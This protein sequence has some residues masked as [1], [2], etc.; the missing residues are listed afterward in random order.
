MIVV[1]MILSFILIFWVT[2]LTSQVSD[3]KKTAQ[4]NLEVYDK[5]ISEIDRAFDSEREQREYLLER[6]QDVEKEI[7]K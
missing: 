3:L 4:Y 6:I 1:L 5:K 2:R 7:R